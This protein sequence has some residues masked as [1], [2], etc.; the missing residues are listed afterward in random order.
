MERKP[1]V[2]TIP[3]G[4]SPGLT[5]APGLS[6]CGAF[7]DCSVAQNVPSSSTTEIEVN[8]IQ[9]SKER[10]DRHKNK[11]TSSSEI[12]QTSPIGKSVSVVKCSRVNCAAC[13]VFYPSIFFKSSLTNRKYEVVSNCNLSCSSSNLVYLITCSKCD[14]Q[15][16]GE[17]K[18]KLSKRL[19]GHRSSIKKHA[20]T[21]IA[22]HFNLPGHSVADIRI[23]P[24]EKIEQLPGESVEDV[25]IKR[26]DRERFW[27]LELGTVYPYGLNDRLQSV[28]NVSKNMNNNI[29]VFSLFN[30]RKRRKRSHGRRRN[31]VNRSKITLENLHE[32]FNSEHGGSLHHL[33]TTLHGI[34][35]SALHKVYL[36]CET[37]KILNKDKRFIRIVLDVCCRRLF[38]PVRSNNYISQPRRHFINPLN[39]APPA[40]NHRR[41]MTFTHCF[42]AC[43][44]SL[45]LLV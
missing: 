20:N 9:S 15:Y 24:I 17:T 3:D 33:L 16:V 13:P 10:K 19:S 29:N 11:K 14:N 39:T 8:K 32:V 27:M 28:G 4:S 41:S 45:F 12:Q 2:I 23:Q 43:N 34:G 38:H 5:R 6:L 42:L 40:I 7:N 25:T 30:K 21:F 18:Q 35:L 31:R 36:E 44:Q 1:V 26:L 22:K 37:N